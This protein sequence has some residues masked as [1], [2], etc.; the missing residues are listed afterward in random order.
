MTKRD[1]PVTIS[2]N[3]AGVTIADQIE[4]W[5]YGDGRLSINMLFFLIFYLINFIIAGDLGGIEHASSRRSL[6]VNEDLRQSGVGGEGLR[7]VVLNY[8]IFYNLA[9]HAVGILEGVLF[10]SRQNNLVGWG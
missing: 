8:T 3:G 9:V 2:F 7:G 4:F 6:L 1:Y 5:G 10:L